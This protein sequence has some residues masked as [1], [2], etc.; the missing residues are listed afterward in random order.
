MH[1]DP[2]SS[3]VA[4]LLCNTSR[5]ALRCIPA[6]GA[7]SGIGAALA[8]RFAAPGRLLALTAR[9]QERLD[10]VALACTKKGARVGGAVGE[11]GWLSQ[12]YVPCMV[13]HGHAWPDFMQ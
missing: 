3:S 5:H 12:R 11:P 2:Y 1:R 13:N 6:A 7:S 8:L 10:Q 4:C 9:S